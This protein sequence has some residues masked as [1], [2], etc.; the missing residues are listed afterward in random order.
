MSAADQALAL[1]GGVH[2]GLDC[3]ATTETVNMSLRCFASGPGQLNVLG[4]VSEGSVTL[5]A[6]VKIGFITTKTLFGRV[7][8]PKAE[9]DVHI[10]T[11]LT[12]SQAYKT[13]DGPLFPASP[14]DREFGVKIYSQIPE[15]ITRKGIR[16]NP[17]EVLEGGL[18]GI[19]AGWERLRVGLKLDFGNAA[20]PRRMG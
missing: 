10:R 6:G 8:R 9:R 5:P 12:V 17:V 1:S 3:I 19:P 2:H 13:S 11:L 18:A 20:C 16:P 14:Q 7:R 15:L 4:Q